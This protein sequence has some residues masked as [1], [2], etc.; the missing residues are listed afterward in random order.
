[1]ALIRSYYCLGPYVGLKMYFI[2]SYSLTSNSFRSK[3]KCASR[4][5]T[6]RH[7]SYDSYPIRIRKVRVRHVRAD[8][9]L[10]MLLLALMTCDYAES[11][12]VYFG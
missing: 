6:I 10:D 5:K 4:S 2:V 12:L 11:N 3:S 1:M 8:P 9:S 7:I